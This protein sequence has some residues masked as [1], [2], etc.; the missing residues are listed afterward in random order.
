MSRR[1]SGFEKR[2]LPVGEEFVIL[3]D[4]AVAGIWVEDEFGTRYAA[5]EIPR[6]LARDHNVVVSIDNEYR[7][8]VDAQL[9]R[10]LRSPGRDLL[11]LAQEHFRREGG[12]AVGLA[13]F[14]RARNAFAA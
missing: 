12:I 14:R 13:A 2:D 8:Q 6:V 1:I 11:K 9:L 3:E 5:R 10:G 4:A 7:L